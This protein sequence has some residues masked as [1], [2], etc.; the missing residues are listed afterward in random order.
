MAAVAAPHEE[1]SNAPPPVKKP[2]RVAQ[3]SARLK[4]VTALSDRVRSESRQKRPAPILPTEA[5]RG[6]E[7]PQELNLYATAKAK[8]EV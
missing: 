5:K 3:L 6:G 4:S 8:G 1:R 2:T 7:K